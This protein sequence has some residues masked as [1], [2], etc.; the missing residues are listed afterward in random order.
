MTSSPA[1]NAN[2]VERLSALH[3]LSSLKRPKLEKGVDFGEAPSFANWRGS[4]KGGWAPLSACLQVSFFPRVG[5]H[6]VHSV[7]LGPLP[8]LGVWR[9]LSLPSE[10]WRS[11]SLIGSSLLPTSKP[12]TR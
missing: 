4:S 10:V 7:S 8:L 1:L 9:R 2:F 11:D 6:E 3:P 5:L 12:Q